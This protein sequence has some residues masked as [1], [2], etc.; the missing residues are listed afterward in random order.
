MALDLWDGQ[1]H[2]RS[3]FLGDAGYPT[4]SGTEPL[5][6]C[7]EAEQREALEA[8][9]AAEAE[10]DD[11]GWEPWEPSEPSGCAVAPTASGLWA[12]VIAM[13]GM[14]RRTFAVGVNES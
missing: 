1:L 3:S 7:G 10:D 12:L 2:V 6:A 4:E 14:G 13:L 11:T 8:L 5:P 9:E